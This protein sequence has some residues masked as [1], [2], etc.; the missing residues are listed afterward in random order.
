[1]ATS[2]AP[3]STCTPTLGAWPPCTPTCTPWSPAWPSRFFSCPPACSGTRLVTRLGSAAR[4]IVVTKPSMTANSGSGRPAS[5]QRRVIDLIRRNR[6]GDLRA[7]EVRTPDLG[8]DEKALRCRAEQ[9]DGGIRRATLVQQIQMCNKR[10]A[11]V[12]SGSGNCLTTRAVRTNCAMRSTSRSSNVALAQGDASNGPQR[13][14]SLLS[15]VLEQKTRRRTAG[16]AGRCGCSRA[17]PPALRRTR[18]VRC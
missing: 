15:G 12:P 14:S 2:R 10:G 16:S 1:M 17:R 4:R 9:Q 7:V 5:A 13:I 18:L 3:K 6:L 11:G 8:G